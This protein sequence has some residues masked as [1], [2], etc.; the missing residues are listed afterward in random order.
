MNELRIVP[1][2]TAEIRERPGGGFG[3]TGYAA[4][5]NSLSEDLGGFRE[6]VSPVAFKKTLKDR[7]DVRAL[8][9]HDRNFVLGRTKSGTLRMSTDDHGLHVDV[10]L[11][12]T[13]YARDLHVL[14]ERGD[15]NQM[16]FAFN[17]I[18]DSWD[19]GSTPPTR[20][21]N[22]V[23]LHDVSIVTVPAYPETSAE[24]RSMAE[25][26]IAEAVGIPGLDVN[27]RA[28]SEYIE[29]LRGGTAPSRK[30]LDLASAATEALTQILSAAE[31]DSPT[32]QEANSAPAPAEEAA[33]RKPLSLA[34][35]RLD[36][37]E[38]L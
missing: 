15:V 33:T 16:S 3:F 38:R 21:L 6:L 34:R 24:A 35:A 28:L 36:L 31:P 20:T 17:T 10:D 27:F 12:D 5:F 11:P 1:F 32:T 13:S 23:R 22:E 18:K 19:S 9:N 14:M 25:T 4:V 2:Q 26:I 8:F 37:I 30:N 29:T 7:A